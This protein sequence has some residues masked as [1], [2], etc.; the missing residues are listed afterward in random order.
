M[1][2]ASHKRQVPFWMPLLICA[3]ILA[4]LVIAYILNSMELQLVFGFPLGLSMFFLDGPW[5][6]DDSSRADSLLLLI[7]LPYCLYIAL[8]IAIFVARKW[9][10]FGMACFVLA[11]VLVL[12]LAGSRHGLAYVQPQAHAK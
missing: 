1:K 11:C 12:N 2:E 8:L 3:I 6:K 7:T 9:S 4:V 5:P 10:S